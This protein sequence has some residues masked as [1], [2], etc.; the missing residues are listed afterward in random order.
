MY[1]PR[2]R[3]EH[4]PALYRL[5]RSRGTTMTALVDEAVGALLAQDEAQAAIAAMA[6][7]PKAH[8][9]PPGA[10]RTRRHDKVR[11]TGLETAAR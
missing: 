5:A 3:D 6:I 10:S 2:I 9:A 1:S 8:P 4:I 7:P 11:R